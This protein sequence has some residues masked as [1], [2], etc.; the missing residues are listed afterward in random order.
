MERKAILDEERDRF[1]M[2][3]NTIIKDGRPVIYV[4]ETTFNSWIVSDKSWSHAE[5]P[6]YQII[7]DQ[8]YST[9]VIGAI[10][11]SFEKP[12]YILTDN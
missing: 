9:S 2:K 5:T 8:R 4:D 6:V 12:V 11:T 3:L 7:S 1:A 10:S